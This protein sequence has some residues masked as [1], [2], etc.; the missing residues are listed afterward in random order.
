MNVRN[1]S[2]GNQDDPI[3]EKITKTKKHTSPNINKRLS[4]F[5]SAAVSPKMVKGIPV[6]VLTAP[7]C[8]QN[9]KG[10]FAFQF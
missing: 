5:D 7:Q 9:G 3:V 6:P 10:D 2:N 8:L 1:A 4:S